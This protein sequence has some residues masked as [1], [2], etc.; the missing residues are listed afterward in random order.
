MRGAAHFLEVTTQVGCGNRCSYCPQ[1]AF[2]RAAARRPQRAARLG[3]E[4]FRSCLA[5]LP[6]D[7]G[8]IFSGYAEPFLNPACGEMILHAAREGRD[9]RVYTTLV[10]LTRQVLERIR[11][12]AFSGFCVH[13][14]EDRGLTE[15]PVDERYLALLEDALRAD[16]SGLYFVCNVPEATGGGVHPEIGPR[17]QRHGAKLRINTLHTRADTVCS[18]G[19]RR[20]ARLR[21]RL[22]GCSHFD[23]HVL[24]PNGDVS[25]CCND[26]GLRHVLGNLLRDDFASLR[27]SA[28]YRRIQRGQH[29][30][31]LDVLCRTCEKAARA[32]RGEGRAIP[33]EIAA[34][35]TDARSRS[36]P[37]PSS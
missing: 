8:V 37:S 27:R 23:Q 19:V 22:R 24:L 6:P 11:E 17:L 5:K 36:W 16:L 15:I 13:V 25:L 26:F 28:E 30:E 33:A 21:G 1:D 9:V 31:S 7:H 29:D 2:G 35:Q 18:P 4:A 12:V 34:L 3:L 14:P 32:L 20:P 10:G